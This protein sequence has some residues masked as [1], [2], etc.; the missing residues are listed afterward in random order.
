MGSIRGYL[1]ESLA[2][3]LLAKGGEFQVKQFIDPYTR[4][5]LRDYHES[6]T[7]SLPSSSSE[8]SVLLDVNSIRNLNPLVYGRPASSN[9]PTVD[10]LKKPNMLFQ[11][12]VSDK[13]SVNVDGLKILV[14]GLIQNPQD[15]V[16]FY[17]VVPP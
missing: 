5:R 8:Q 17:F 14:D 1:H 12:T 11:M 3:G 2:H 10:G 9:F 13:H 15:K 4:A 7:L 16:H 6:K